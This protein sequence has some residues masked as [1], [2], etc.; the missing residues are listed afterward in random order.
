MSVKINQQE[1]VHTQKGNLLIFIKKLIDTLNYIES[2]SPIILNRIV[3]KLKTRVTDE[4]Y[5]TI[6]LN[7]MQFNAFVYIY[8][9]FK[10]FFSS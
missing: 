6:T 7:R 5:S 3:D 8:V 1:E 4:N 2:Y 9:F 10:I